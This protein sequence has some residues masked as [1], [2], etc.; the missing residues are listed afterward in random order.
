MERERAILVAMMPIKSSKDD[1]KEATAYV[2]AGYLSAKKFA[3]LSPSRDLIL[4]A[5]V[6][7]PDSK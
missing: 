6:I 3:M 5:H 1:H 4:T 7:C 2:P